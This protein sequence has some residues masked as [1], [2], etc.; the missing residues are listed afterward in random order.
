M[1]EQKHSIYSFDLKYVLIGRVAS[2]FKKKKLE[3]NIRN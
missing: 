2:L 3:E 1:L